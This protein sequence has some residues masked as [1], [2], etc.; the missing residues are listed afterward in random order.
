MHSLFHTAEEP[1]SYW[2]PGTLD[3][4]KWLSPELKL[5]SPPIVTLD[6]GP[7]VHLLVPEEDALAWIEK[8]QSK[9]NFEL[10]VDRQGLGA[11]WS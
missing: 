4:L 7:N 5:E 3:V 11:Q 1:F 9:F 6:A 8:I 10:L 2:E